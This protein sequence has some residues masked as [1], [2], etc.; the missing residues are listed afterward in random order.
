M[1]VYLCN[2]WSI[3]LD[4]CMNRTL[5]KKS[6]KAVEIT[7]MSRLARETHRNRREKCAETKSL[8]VLWLFWQGFLEVWSR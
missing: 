3:K 2:K 7:K 6:E 1:I 5:M 8:G 4:N